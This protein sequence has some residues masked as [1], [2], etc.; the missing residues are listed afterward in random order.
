MPELS[1]IEATEI[2]RQTIPQNKQPKAI[3]GEF[4]D[5]LIS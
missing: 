1:G 3:I 2:I 4:C 5:R